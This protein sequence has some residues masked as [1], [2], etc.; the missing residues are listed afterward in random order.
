MKILGRGFDSRR[1]HH[2]IASH[3]KS[4]TFEMALFLLVKSRQ[5]RKNI[6]ILSLSHH[7][8]LSNE[9]A[10]EMELAV[11]FDK[12]TS[13]FTTE[14]GSGNKLEVATAFTEK[15]QCDG[16]RPMQLILVGLAACMG[17]NVVSILKKMRQA[18]SDYRIKIRATRAADTPRVFT[19]I[20]MDHFVCGTKISSHALRR[21]VK[22]SEEKYCSAFAMFKQTVA[23]SSEIHVLKREE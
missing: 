22:L 15:T 11:Q 2:F 17:T 6:E 13:C 7:N 21:A 16:L 19:S 4:L 3:F 8:I 12:N 20:K 5:D 9:K 1:L 10:G 18:F 23:M 14:T